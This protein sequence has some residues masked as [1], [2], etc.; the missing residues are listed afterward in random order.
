MCWSEGVR[1]KGANRLNFFFC[2]INLYLFFFASMEPWSQ[3]P[4]ISFYLSRDSPHSRLH[5]TPTIYLYE[6]RTRTR[7][8]RVTRPLPFPLQ[9]PKSSE[10][11]PYRPNY[12][13]LLCILYVPR[14][15]FGGEESAQLFFF[16]VTRLHVK[17]IIICM[18]RYLF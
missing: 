6:I 5:R 1:N 18:Y 14:L 9:E 12:Y 16:T 17:K 8:R 2:R 15:T 10:G 7:G 4:K 11:I 3:E 13:P